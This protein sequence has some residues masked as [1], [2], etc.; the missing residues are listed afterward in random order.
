MSHGLTVH[1]IHRPSLMMKKGVLSSLEKSSAKG[2]VP[3][4]S[5]L[6]A[7]QVDQS[8][9]FSTTRFLRQSILLLVVVTLG[10]SGR[11]NSRALKMRQLA[12]VIPTRENYLEEDSSAQ[13]LKREVT[14]L[15]TESEYKA[16]KAKQPESLLS[17]RNKQAGNTA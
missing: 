17:T 12:L 2:I 3:L 11:S 15:S 4:H 6:S 14:R 13:A 1:P 5:R 7:L 8:E 9:N 16:Q 10:G